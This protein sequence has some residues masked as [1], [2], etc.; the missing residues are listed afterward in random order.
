MR[1]P[2]RIWCTTVLIIFSVINSWSQVI[3]LDHVILAVPDIDSAIS[4]VSRLGFKIKPGTIHSNGLKN[5][6]IKFANDT[7][8]ELM[9]V[10]GQPGD[11][12]AKNYQ[13]LINDK[14]IGAFVAFSGISVDSIS[15]MLEPQNI[16]HEIIQERSWKYLTFE[17]G[18]PLAA[19]FF[20]EYGSRLPTN[21]QY[22]VHTSRAF[23]FDFVSL[24]AGK[25]LRQVLQL[26][27]PAQATRETEFYTPTGTIRYLPIGTG[28]RPRIREIQFKHQPNWDVVKIK[29]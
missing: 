17:Q 3:K 18:G 22:Y 8:L 27:A 21:K 28:Q 25:E 6:H 9:T 16:K 26:I 5:V 19:I 20:I 23:A 15:A 29:L 11:A 4:Y 12:I 1:N 13:A 10:V 24:A 2:L 14:T 7:E